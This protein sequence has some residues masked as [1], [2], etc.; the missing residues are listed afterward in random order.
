MRYLRARLRP[1]DQLA[2]S[3]LKQ[4]P[5]GKKRKIMPVV[6]SVGKPGTDSKKD[7]QETANEKIIQT[8]LVENEELRQKNRELTNELVENE[9]LRQKNR[10]L[11]KEL[12][13]KALQNEDLVIRVEQLEYRT[14]QL[15]G[16]L[17][18]R[19]RRR[20]PR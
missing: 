10:E 6:V 18:Q 19:F 4:A 11:T 8:L 15:K 1:S 2:M 20:C 7:V 9:E 13:Q 3:D 14:R 17:N 12:R 5:E 16:A